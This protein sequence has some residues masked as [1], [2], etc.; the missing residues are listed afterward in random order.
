MFGTNKQAVVYK[1]LMN[2][3]Y[4]ANLMVIDVIESHNTDYKY[5]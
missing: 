1:I 4:C 2:A 5:Y 3:C